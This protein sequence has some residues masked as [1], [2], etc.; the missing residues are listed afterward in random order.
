M[1]CCE[2]GSNCKGPAWQSIAWYFSA[3]KRLGDWSRSCSLCPIQHMIGHILDLN[4]LSHLIVLTG[5]L[6]IAL[7]GSLIIALTPC[8]VVLRHHNVTLILN[9]SYITPDEGTLLDSFQGTWITLAIILTPGTYD[10]RSIPGT[11]IH[12]PKALICIPHVLNGT[13]VCYDQQSLSFLE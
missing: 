1:L 5:S 11:H 8:L 13:N 9:Q 6:I 3:L 4:I 10:I 7:T 12:V 2:L